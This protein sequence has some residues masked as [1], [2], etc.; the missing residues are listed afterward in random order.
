MRTSLKNLITILVVIVLVPSIIYIM[1]LAISKNTGLGYQIISSQSF[2]CM[3]SK[4]DTLLKQ[5]KNLSEKQ[6]E[7]FILKKLMTEHKGLEF[8]NKQF[9]FCNYESCYEMNNGYSPVVFRFSYRKSILIP[10]KY[11][12]N[13]IVDFRKTFTCE[14]YAEY[15]TLD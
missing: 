2:D 14:R 7:K 15:G 9:G 13:D 12:E 6:N 11:F 10:S 4:P 5:M 1:V 8:E 3:V